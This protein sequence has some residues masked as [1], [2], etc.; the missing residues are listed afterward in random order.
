MEGSAMG[1]SK[2]VQYRCSFCGKSQEQV[3]RLIAG[4]G[5]VYIC[6]QCIELCQEIMTQEGQG[7]AEHES[8]WRAKVGGPGP[9]G[10][11]DAIEDV[12][13]TVVQLLERYE[14]RLRSIEQRLA[15]LEQ[16]P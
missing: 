5:G 12:V 15:S 13:G 16:K 1:Q 14:D 6:N 7:E 4:P 10:S 3:R 8:G 11:G 2:R 9:A